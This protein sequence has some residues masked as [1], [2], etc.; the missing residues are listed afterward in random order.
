M[1]GHFYWINHGW[2]PIYRGGNYVG[3]SDGGSDKESP[4]SNGM[5]NDVEFDIEIIVEDS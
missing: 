3:Y 4:D 5:P 1:R 2:Y